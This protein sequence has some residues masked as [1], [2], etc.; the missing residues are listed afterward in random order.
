MN[1]P[2]KCL[3]LNRCNT[4]LL[5]MAK[6]YDTVNDFEILQTLSAKLRWSHLIKLITI[7]EP[8][9]R[10]FYITMSIN[11]NNK[12]STQIYFRDPYVLDCLGLQ[13]TYNEKDL[14]NAILADL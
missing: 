9:K 11:E 13:D 14:E 5:N 8:L 2:W 4:N 12:I 7:N 3:W 6:L 10:Q 1:N